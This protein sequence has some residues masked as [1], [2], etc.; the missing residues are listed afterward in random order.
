MYQSLRISTK[1]KMKKISREIADRMIQKS[2]PVRSKIDQ[3]GNE[4][5]VTFNLLNGMLLLVRYNGRS[6]HKTYFLRK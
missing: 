5:C 1:L 6:L 3:E 4:L 2:H